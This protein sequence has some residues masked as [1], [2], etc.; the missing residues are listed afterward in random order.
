VVGAFDSLKGEVPIGLIVLKTGVTR[1]SREI[2][3]DVIQMVRERIGPVACFKIAAIVDRLPKTRS[4]K[5]VRSTI[6]RIA[7]GVE[8]QIPPTIEDLSTIEEV[9]VSLMSI[10]YARNRSSE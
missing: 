6:K 3:S 8:Y 1:S 4:G 9:A 10:G 7:D 2:V 5:I